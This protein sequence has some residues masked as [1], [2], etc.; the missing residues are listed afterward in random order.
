MFFCIEHSLLVIWAWKAQ[1]KGLR[2]KVLGVWCISHHIPKVG[3]FLA[4]LLLLPG[5][6]NAQEGFFERDAVDVDAPE[7]GSF[8]AVQVHN[9]LGDVS[10]RGHDGSGIAIQSFKRAADKET[11]ERLIVSL[12][13]DTQGRVQIR[14]TFRPGTEPY[15]VAA[16]SISVD[17]VVL[18]PRSAE[19]QAELWRGNLRVSSLDNGAR[20][21]VDRGRIE[22]KQVSGLVVS[23]LRKGEQGFTEVFGTLE[24]RGIEGAIGLR[25]IQGKRLVAS[26]VRGD[27]HGEGLKVKSMAVQAVF[28]DIE[29]VALPVLGGRYRV[30]SRKGNVQ[31]RFHGAIPMQ[32]QV[33]AAK[34]MLGPE[35]AAEQQEG[36]WHAQFVPAE[37]KG[38]K[39]VR[40]AQLEVRAAAGQVLVRHF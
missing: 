4:G 26:L 20:L 33:A 15:P 12:I 30:T 7:G 16:G 2:P 8:T 9:R 31:F 13:P 24:T 10:V 14:T 19:V 37:A 17:L 1:F 3:L 35:L 36:V 28:G 39:V 34:A 25:G 5:L 38:K 29:L 23:D 6:A 40:P 32:I 27:I 11:L 18:V 22:V 21:L